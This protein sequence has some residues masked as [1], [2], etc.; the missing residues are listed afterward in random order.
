[1]PHKDLPRRAAKIL[2][3][4]TGLALLLVQLPAGA[5]D[6]SK[7]ASPAPSLSLGTRADN[8]FVL[9]RSPIA[10]ARAL[11]LSR[12][13]PIS[14]TPDLSALART[15]TPA[16][17]TQ[18]DPV[19]I[20]PTAPSSSVEST[21]GRPRGPVFQSHIPFTRTEIAD[22]TQSPFLIH[23]KVVM[24]FATGTGLCSGTAVT[25]NN[26]SVVITAG[27]CLMDPSSGETPG[28]IRFLPGF[29]DGNTPFGE[30]DAIA[31]GVTDEWRASIQKGAADPRY[32]V[33]AF[34]LGPDP[35]GSGQN[36]ADLLGA[37][38][39]AFNQPPNQLFDSFGYPVASPFN[40]N[41]LFLCDSS[42]SDL[43]DGIPPPQPHGIG[44]DMT[45]GSSGGGWVLN[46]SVVNSVNSFKLVGHDDVMYG[47]QFGPSAQK[48]YNQA[49]NFD[50]DATPTTHKMT[51]SLK[52]SGHL[53]ASGTIKA[54]DGFKP[55]A[56]R[57]PIQ[58][59]R[60]KLSSSKRP[61][62]G[63]VVKTTKSNLQGKFRMNGPDKPGYYYV[64]SPAG[65]LTNSPDL[66]SA[67]KSV[68]RAH[69][70]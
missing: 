14:W 11:D 30:W 40:G 54:K 59:F 45:P 47:P 19:L 63:K 32:D 65:G 17:L 20:A 58:L 21:E 50:P 68:V 37:R 27:H 33:G 4:L 26:A 23:G 60:K 28:R 29:K 46:D 35:N 2:A 22:P 7:P 34:V 25:S 41:R 8:W 12:A 6:D 24:N 49:S 13:K 9:D 31:F 36:I 66:C 5:A 42:T 15:L 18:A 69:R 44:C 51:V 67:A 52:L 57:A 53:V 39:I 1:M 61:R 64:K 56:R 16:P 70:H 38:G 43:L 48:L 55:C 62:G 10:H 3:L